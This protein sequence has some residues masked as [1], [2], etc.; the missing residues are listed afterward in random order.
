MIIKYSSTVKDLSPLLKNK[1][2][3]EKG[4]YKSEFPNSEPKVKLR[5]YPTLS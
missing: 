5:I 1:K 3:K 2:E 4:P